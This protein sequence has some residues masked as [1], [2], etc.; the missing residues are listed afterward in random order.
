MTPSGNKERKG[1]CVNRAGSVGPKESAHHCGVSGFAL[2]PRA[3]CNT[4]HSLIR[5]RGRCV[6]HVT[7][8]GSKQRK[9]ANCV[10]FPET[11]VVV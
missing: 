10:S 7:P 1:A 4:L 6:N 2:T 11:V 3:L 8:G 9:G 5:E